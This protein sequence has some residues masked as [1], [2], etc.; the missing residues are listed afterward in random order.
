MR[1]EERQGAA[2][3]FGSCPAYSD[4]TICCGLHTLDAVRGCPFAC[5]Y[6]TIQTFY[7]EIAEI[8][9][10]LAG[11]LSRL[12][13][14]PQRGYHIGTGQASDSLAWGNRGGHLDALLDFA[15]AHP[16][17]LLE[18]KTKSARVDDLLVRAVPDNVVVSW[19]MNTPA[20][21]RNE[22][23]GTASLDQRLTAARSLADHRVAVAFHFHPMV[24]YEG[25]NGDYP[26][27]AARLRESFEPSE[28]WFISM[29]SVTFIKPVVHEIRRRGGATKILQME[30]V[31]DSHGKLTYPDSVKLQ[32]FRRLYESFGPWREEVFFYLCMETAALWQQVLGRSYLTNRDF[33]REFLARC[34]VRRQAAADDCHP[35]ATIGT[36]LGPIRCAPRPGPI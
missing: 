19:S 18:L 33:E 22:E 11:Q 30:M 36:R 32:L 34:L 15:S 26:A 27:V 29:G 3:I 31:A 20:I 8:E 21:I 25:W 1:L 2:R 7:P 16:N 23:H 28:V 4:R 6:C 13:L 12:D 5:T 10:D 9:A 35:A 14:D 17:V 24:F